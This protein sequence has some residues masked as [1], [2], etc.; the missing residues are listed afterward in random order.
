MFNAGR[1]FNHPAAGAIGPKPKVM[2]KRAPSP[3]GGPA[4]FAGGHAEA[5]VEELTPICRKKTRSDHKAQA[6]PRHDQR[7]QASTGDMDDATVAKKDKPN[8]KNEHPDEP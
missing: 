3:K 5:E 2:H 7:A 1:A 6:M 8:M 4:A